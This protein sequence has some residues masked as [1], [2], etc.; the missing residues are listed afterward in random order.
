ME[1]KRIESLWLA[2]TMI[3]MLILQGKEVMAAE[4]MPAT[5]HNNMHHR[6]AQ[7][8]PS[9]G[10]V[11][12]SHHSRKKMSM[13]GGSA[14]HDARDPHA[15]SDGYDFGSIAPPR[16]AD[17]AYRS[18]LLFNQFER[19]QARDNTTTLYDVLG[20]FGKDYEHAVFKAEGDVEAAKLIEA[21]TELLWGHAVTAYWDTQL[22]VRYDSGLAP[23]QPWLA[24]GLLG[25]APYWF[26]VDATA[27][28]GKQGR[29]AVRLSA[30]YELLI[31]QKLIMQPSV[32]A[33]LYGKSDSR[34]DIGSG[35]SSAQAGLRLRYE[36][37]RQF[38]PYVGVEWTGKFG[39]TAN[40]SR[41]T[42]ARVNVSRVLA[43][44]RFWF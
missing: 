32:E 9:D 42:G 14:P 4:N 44:L 7:A 41:A 2:V 24:F 27:Y 1:T 13:Q 11:A 35:L 28:I 10:M 33:N 16:L 8:E 19:A 29:T 12:P 21:R 5:D 34:R 17:Q 31:T 25:L 30:E 6:A 3:A 38:A 37:T 18:S 39:G 20:K 15:Y 43:G 23:D 36:F 22:G 26:E 40:F